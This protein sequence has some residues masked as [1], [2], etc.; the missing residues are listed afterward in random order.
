MILAKN[1]MNNTNIKILT[2]GAVIALALIGILAF[3][4][5]IVEPPK[6]AALC[7]AHKYSIDNNINEFT[8]TIS[9]EQNDSIYTLIFNKIAIFKSEQFLV[10]SEI[11][12]QKDVLIKR[13]VPIFTKLCYDKFNA[14]VWESSELKMISDRIA[15]LRSLKNHNGAKMIGRYE[16]SLQQVDQIIRNYRTAMNIATSSTFRSS[17]DAKSKIQM[18]DK[19]RKM[20]PLSNCTEL[21]R[22]LSGVRT[23]MANAHYK[24]ITSCVESMAAYKSMSEESFRGLI[25]KANNAIQEY[26]NTRSMYGNAAKNTDKLN[27]RASA[28]YREAY[29]YY[30]SMNYYYYY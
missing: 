10:D 4:L 28:L 30:N 5:T 15:H 3:V 26:N 2:L 23:N 8:H 9:L 12:Q 14:P 27:Q 21:V 13:F 29:N 1:I 16:G 17:S 7:N 18:A 6:E 11:D 19:Y 20:Y 24:Y 25:A 22:R